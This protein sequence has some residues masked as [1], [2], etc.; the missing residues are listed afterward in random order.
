MPLNVGDLAPNF[1]LPST[2]GKDFVLNDYK[3]QVLVLFFY[4]KD[5][6]GVCT[7]EA[8]TFRDQFMAF[9]NLDV[10][11][12]GISRDDLATHHRFKEKYKLPFDLLA[13]EDGA[14]TKAYKS[15]IPLFGI[16]K[17]VT[18]VLD[19]SHRVAAVVED[20]FDAEIHIKE[21]LEKIRN[22]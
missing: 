12:V 8:C 18:Y 6:T 7:K 16:S 2:A 20:L 5:F 3:G 19:K 10:T 17:R 9:R 4:P 13:D 14:T 22:L 15:A 1:Q 21:T 11:V